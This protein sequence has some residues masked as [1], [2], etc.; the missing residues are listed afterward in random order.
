MAIVDPLDSTVHTY[1][2][3][4]VERAHGDGL[5]MERRVSG[6]EAIM[7]RYD[8]P[9]SSSVGIFGSPETETF[10][11]LEELRPK[12]FVRRSVNVYVATS[13]SLPLM[14]TGRFT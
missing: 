7:V 4:G 13:R 8:G 6:D 10:S 3:A 5:A 11:V 14:A 9:T 12:K 1:F 2:T